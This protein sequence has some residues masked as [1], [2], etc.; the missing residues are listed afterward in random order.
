MK[1]GTECYESTLEPANYRSS[2]RL[3][4]HP[5]RDE[6]D[7]RTQV[8]GIFTPAPQGWG[9]TGLSGLLS[10]PWNKVVGGLTPVE[11]VRI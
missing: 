2:N 11:G 7:Y 4:V 5:A 3:Q 9:S 6:P 1:C 10:S 8:R